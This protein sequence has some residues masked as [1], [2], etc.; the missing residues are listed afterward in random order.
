[1]NENIFF[2]LFI[3]KVKATL[4][5]NNNNNNNVEKNKNN[6]VDWKQW[7]SVIMFNTRTS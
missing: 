6:I 1:M 5:V 2:I 4:I 3:D 7:F